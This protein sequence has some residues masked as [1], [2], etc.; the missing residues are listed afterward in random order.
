[1]NHSCSFNCVA[2]YEA[3]TKKQIFRAT[4][5]IQKGQE[6]VCSYIDIAASTKT[7]RE[8]LQANYHFVCQCPSCQRREEQDIFCD[9]C[10]ATTYCDP[11]R[12][13]MAAAGNVSE[14][15]R[16]LS[17]RVSALNC[18][19]VH[20][21]ELHS[22]LLELYID[23]QNWLPA[24]RHAESIQKIYD[25]IYGAMKHPIVGLHLYTLGD[26]TW[27]TGTKQDAVS[28]RRRVLEYLSTTHGTQHDLTKQ[29]RNI[30][31]HDD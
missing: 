16:A 2:T 1:M 6:I 10:T 7:R 21:L 11:V 13:T 30:L 8:K 29:L 28:I 3:K 14:I 26:L 27:A 15:E 24:T 23:Q 25:L 20:V 22:R 18:K 12:K 31:S 4:R 5:A 17:C 9:T 19:H